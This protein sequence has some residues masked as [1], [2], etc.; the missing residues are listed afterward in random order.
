MGDGGTS[1]TLLAPPESKQEHI[2]YD[3]TPLQRTVDGSRGV[4]PDRRVIGPDA[5]QVVA[6]RFGDPVGC[7]GPGIV[8]HL[9]EA[10]AAPDRDCLDTKSRLLAFDSNIMT[11]RS[12]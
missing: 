10:L 9:R 6:N 1:D 8:R 3:A 2:G 11:S 7:L 4:L 12:G 5:V